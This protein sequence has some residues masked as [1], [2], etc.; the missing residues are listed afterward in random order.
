MRGERCLGPVLFHPCH[1]AIAV[2]A[3]YHLPR[4][5]RLHAQRAHE[6]P[7]GNLRKYSK[8]VGVVWSVCRP[9][10]I[11]F[12]DHCRRDVQ[13]VGQQL[14]GRYRSDRGSE[15]FR[16]IGSSFILATAKK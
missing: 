12:N 2:L 14:Q 11:L 1:S 7:R 10:A 3:N 5:G 4:F 13:H 16:D 6:V 9:N 8:Y 15:Q